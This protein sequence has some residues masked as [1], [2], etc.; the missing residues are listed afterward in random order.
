M[1]TFDKPPCYRSYL[2]TVWWERS[3]DPLEAVAWRFRLED[4]RTGQRHGF[5]SL[6]ALVA[7]LQRE[8]AEQSTDDRRSTADPRSA[9]DDG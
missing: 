4:P 1:N 3:Q 8:M 9:L 7:A 2:L 6:D 5:A